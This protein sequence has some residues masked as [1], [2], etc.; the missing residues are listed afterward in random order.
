MGSTPFTRNVLLISFSAFFADFGYQ[1][2]TALFALMLIFRYHEPVYVYGIITALAFGVGSLFAYLGGRA[3][4]R[5]SRKRVS[6]LGNL[7]IP[8]MALSGAFTSIWIAGLLFVV[9]WWSRY[10]RSPAR[11]ALLVDVSDPNARSQVFGLLHALDIGGGLLS[12]LVAVLFVSILHVPIEATMLVLAIPLLVSTA[13][14]FFVRTG[15]AR[16]A[17]R[18]A[19]A[20]RTARTRLFTKNPIFVALLFATTFYGFSFYNAGYPVIS[21][22]TSKGLF[23]LGLIAYAIYLGASAVSGYVFGSLK[24][25]AVRALWSLGYLPSAIASLLIGLVVLLHAPVAF[26]YVFVALL[27]VGMGSVETFEPTSTSLLVK[28][29]DLSTGMGY[30]SVSRSLGQFASNLIMGIIFTFS[31]SAAYGYAFAASLIATVILA[32]VDRRRARRDRGAARAAARTNT[33]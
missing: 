24:P 21:A 25:K 6:I 7:F 11:R 22:A 27:G 20:A 14:L 4:D 30:L 2:I 17:P 28:R 1:G 16:R 10:F 3:G 26:F 8:L 18:A 13:L 9:G 5:Y 19:K 31:Q 33:G 23:D 29:E 12:A 15:K 32:V